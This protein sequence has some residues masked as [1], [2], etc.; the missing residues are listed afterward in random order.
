MRTQDPVPT[1]VFA[2]VVL[3]YERYQDTIHVNT[4]ESEG[5]QQAKISAGAKHY[6]HMHQQKGLTSKPSLDGVD[7]SA[8][9]RLESDSPPHNPL[10]MDVPQKPWPRAPAPPSPSTAYSEPIYSGTTRNPA[11]FLAIL[12]I[13]QTNLPSLDLVSALNHIPNIAP[14]DALPDL[15]PAAPGNL[16]A[17]PFLDTRAPRS[18]R[19][20]DADINIA[21]LPDFYDRGT[22]HALGFFQIQRC[23]RK[24][25][26][27][28]T[29]FFTPCT[30]LDLRK[31]G[32]VEYVD[33]ADEVGEGGVDTMSRV[34]CEEGEWRD[35]DTVE[36]Y[37]EW[38][39]MYRVAS[40]AWEAKLG[41]MRGDQEG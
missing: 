20:G 14:S 36:E 33:D 28:G 5:S 9:A 6:V 16:A 8:L 7:Y 15:I 26:L 21:F 35:R 10:A 24:G 22:R 31:Y 32:L 29:A 19:E 39:L 25:R 2:P 3:R 34:A 27:L 18:K 13:A 11:V 40:V 37:E 17:R 4:I 1:E 23:P 12:S 30:E 38:K 41:L